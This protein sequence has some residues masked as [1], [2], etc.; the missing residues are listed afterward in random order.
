[1]SRIPSFGISARNW[2]NDSSESSAWSPLRASGSTGDF[3]RA[4]DLDCVRPFF[5]CA[6]PVPVLP[7]GIFNLLW[8]VGV[9]S[10]SS[11]DSDARPR[12]GAAQTARAECPAMATPAPPGHDSRV[13]SH[14][15]TSEW[16]EWQAALRVCGRL[17]GPALGRAAASRAE[18]AGAR[19]GHRGFSVTRKAS[20]RR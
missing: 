2:D 19:A 8:F 6:S 16:A 5:R 7:L 14:A 17:G 4:G 10:P 18:S 11:P 20:L 13:I 1:M 12:G 9:S 15:K 3:D